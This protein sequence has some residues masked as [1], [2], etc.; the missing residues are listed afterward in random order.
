VYR[1]KVTGIMEFGCFVELTGF[2]HLGKKVCVVSQYCLF[3]GVRSS[4]DSPV[5]CTRRGTLGHRHG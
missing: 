3:Q 1:G 4:C 2:G 5:V